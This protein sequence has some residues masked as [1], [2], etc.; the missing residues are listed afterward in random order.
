MRILMPAHSIASYKKSER[1]FLLYQYLP[2]GIDHAKSLSEIMVDYS[3]DP[4]KYNSERKTLENDLSSLQGIFS[5]LMYTD[6]EALVR[7]PQWGENIS[8][9]T[10]TFY[11]DKDFRIDIIDEQT[12][13]FWEM[14]TNFTAHYLPVTI[15]RTLTDQ[16]NRI[17]RRDKVAF[18]KSTLG[19][20]QQ[21]LITLPSVLQAPTLDSEVMAAI[22]QALLTKR[23]LEIEYHN[24]WE[25]KGVWRTIYP[26]GLVFID[27]MMCLTGFNP[28]DDHIDDDVLLKSHRN[29]AVNRIKAATV[30]ETLL[31][32][33]VNRDAFSLT[34]LQKTGKLEPTDSHEIKLL[35]KVQKQACQHLY[36]RPLS[37]DQCITNLSEHW[38]RVTA[39][40][41]HTQRLQDWLVSMSQLAVVI[42]PQ[43]LKEGIYE[44]LNKA[45]ELYKDE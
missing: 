17:Q 24:K 45:V 15:Q 44:R 40:V 23:I 39:T 13:F 30:G 31:P 3:D 26:I 8:G 16:L 34:N 11:I 2:R 18:E 32:D 5:E 38:N 1:L 36:E 6:T 41:A 37:D 22:H 25:N 19:Q 10:A 29:F 27:N 43:S 20:W 42:E 4:A 28:S 14:L 9:K 33:W 12:L 35:L 21:Y 7:Q